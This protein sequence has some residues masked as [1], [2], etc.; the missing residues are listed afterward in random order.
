MLLWQRCL[1]SEQT[2]TVQ[3]QSAQI[4]CRK[5]AAFRDSAQRRSWQ[6]DPNS[7]PY[8][9]FLPLGQAI[10]MFWIVPLV[11]VLIER[12]VFWR[13]QGVRGK[14]IKK[15]NLDAMSVDEI[16]QL[17]EEIE[18]ILPVLL[19]AKKRVLEM[20]LEQ[21]RHDD[22]QADR[23][24]PSEDKDLQRTPKRKYPPVYPKYLNPKEPTET[25]SGRGNMPRWLAE[26][27]RIGHKLEEFAVGNAIGMMVGEPKD[28]AHNA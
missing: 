9:N 17:H 20:R 4:S 11:W 18:R 12:I 2:K 13:S 7:M 6:I 28:K 22:K 25:W 1:S 24:E 10:L 16:W 23:T 8:G 14:M 3:F 21:L 5:G 15:M 27:L 19:R 26:A